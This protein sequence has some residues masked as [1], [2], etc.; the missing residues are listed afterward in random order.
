M[1][2]VNLAFRVGSNRQWIEL[3]VG[4]GLLTPGGHKLRSITLRPNG[5]CHQDHK[6]RNHGTAHG[7]FHD[8][9]LNTRW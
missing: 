2:D 5:G 7:A 1:D 4:R 6:Q 8:T 9:A 3:A